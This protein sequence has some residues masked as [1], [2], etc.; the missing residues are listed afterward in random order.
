MFPV[1]CFAQISS[2]QHVCV[3][4]GLSVPLPA[5]SKQGSSK[6]SKA[7]SPPSNTTLTL[8]T[9]HGFD[10]PVGFLP[11]SL[12]QRLPG[13]SSRLCLAFDGETGG[14]WR[15]APRPSPGCH[16]SGRGDVPQDSA[17]RP[18]AAD[19]GVGKP[20]RQSP[21]QLAGA[22][23]PQHE[24]PAATPVPAATQP[25]LPTRGAPSKTR[26]WRPRAMALTPLPTVPLSSS[27]AGEQ[28]RA[29]GSWSNP[30]TSPGPGTPQGWHREVGRLRLAQHKAPGEPKL[31]G[32]QLGTR[33]PAALQTASGST[34]GSQ[35]CH[36]SCLGPSG[37]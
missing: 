11:T 2:R 22:G 4:K 10:T 3:C 6:L 32:A 8:E 19:A 7:Y 25:L 20:H 30:R 12:C 28:P 34:E 27:A 18:P 5:A 36:R 1:P 29:L 24:H 16:R 14:R 13:G 21:P 9:V 17:A 31:G 23:A 15:P 37:P 26:T 35:L 33:G